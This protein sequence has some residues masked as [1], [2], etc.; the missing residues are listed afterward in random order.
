[1]KILI[2]APTAIPIPVRGYGG[3]E[4]EAQWFAEA[5]VKMGH[6][7]TLMGNVEEGPNPQGWEGIRLETET[8]PIRVDRYPLLRSFDV[9]HDFSHAK[10]CRLVKF[11]PTTRYLSTTMWTD[12]Q[13]G[14]DVYPSQA[15][16]E[17]FKD[18]KAPV[19]PLGI[20]L[21][22]A[23]TASPP[24]GFACLGRIASFKGQDLAIRIAKAMNVPLVVAGHQGPFGDP[25]YAL[26]V[27]R[28]CQEAGFSFIPNPPSLDDLLE[29]CAGLVHT[30]RWLESF[31]LIAAQALVRGVPILTTDQGAPQEWVRATDGGLIVPLKE[32]E[33][34]HWE[35]ARPFFDIN[36][37]SRRLGIMKR[38]RAMFDIEKV[39]DAYAPL[40]GGGRK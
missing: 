14:V 17:A 4:L 37:S 19:I 11:P 13:S 39:L 18:P 8:A 15:V 33:A 34:G 29:N 35:V 28:M 26:T 40:Y 1:M 3:I 32:L 6:A 38:A 20:P 22:E 24:S 10:V 25:Y 21:G 23:K 27:R 7:V 2:I 9:V 16:R 36:W 5:L 30:H 12:T 31:S